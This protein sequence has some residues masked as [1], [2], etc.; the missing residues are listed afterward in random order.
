MTTRELLQMPDSEYMNE[1]QLAYFRAE[2]QKMRAEIIND[3]RITT[4][5]LRETPR[6][7]DELD[8]AAREEEQSLE[9]RLRERE[10]TLLRKIDQAMKRIQDGTYGYCDMTGEPIGLRRLLARPTATLSIEAKQQAETRE[11]SYRS[12]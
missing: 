8:R 9:I 11:R 1:A 4:D 2:L 5:H 12:P 10:A 7:A 3:I 6:A